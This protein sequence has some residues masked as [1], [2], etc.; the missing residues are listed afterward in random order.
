MNKILIILRREY[1]SRV[2]KKS[3]IVMTLL[4]PALFAGFL[5]IPAWFATMD[6]SE[7]KQIAVIDSSQLFLKKIPDTEHFKFT[8]A[9]NVKPEDFK[10]N[11]AQTEYFGILYIP[12]YIAYTPSGTEFFSYRQPPAGLI[13][14]ISNA[15]EKTIEK[16]KLKAHQIENLDEILRSVS[17]RI[18]IRTFKLSEEGT[19]KES[20]GIVNTVVAYVSAFLIYLF[21]FMFGAQVMRGVMEEKTGRVVEIIISSVKPFQLMM[22]KVTGIAMVGLTQFVIWIALTLILVTTGRMFFMNSLTEKALQQ[23]EVY[24]QVASQTGNELS[25]QELMNRSGDLFSMLDSVNFPVL[26]GCFLLFFIGGYLLYGSLFAAIGSA[27]DNDTDSQQ[28]MMPVSLPLIVAFMVMLNV[29]QNPDS[30]V[31]FWFSII[32]FTSPVV[33]MARIPF[34]VPYWEIILS[35]G[36]LIVTFIG[37]IRLS[38]KI[39][40]T[41]ILIYG[42]K[43]TWKELWKWMRYGNN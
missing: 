19:E 40:R 34:G 7:V 29:M 17:T 30:T 28:F 13:V 4:G 21:V 2:R 14:H 42:K 1:L 23:G 35:V 5:L 26:I 22:G 32:P 37:V 38:A 25:G 6:D 12:P 39:Y 43:P 16:E 27:V 24:A 36:L 11:L 15:I 31:A 3:F 33:M 10:K 18:D 41:A 20:H 9:M 8:Y